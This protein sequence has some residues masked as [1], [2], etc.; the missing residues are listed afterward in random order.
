MEEFLFV[1]HE[2]RAGELNLHVTHQRYTAVQFDRNVIVD[3]LEVG[4]LVHLNLELTT[5]DNE[6]EN[7][8]H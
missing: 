6:K 8:A 1:L 2:L 3:A 7:V 4:Q 5:I